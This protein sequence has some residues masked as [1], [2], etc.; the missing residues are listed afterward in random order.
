MASTTTRRIVV[1]ISGS[2]S[3]LQALIDVLNTPAL[4]NAQITLVLSNR[5]AAYGL[6]RASQAVPPIPTAYLA[7]QPFLKAN[8]GKTREDYDAEVAKIVVKENPDI[9]VLAGWMHI[10][11]EEFLQFLD[12]RKAVDVGAGQVKY[13]VPVINLHPAL[14]G[15]FDGAHAIER[16]YEA[17]QKGEI[18]HTG[19]MVHKVVKDVDRGEPV[20]VREVPIEKGESIESFE[21]RLHKI[22]HEIIVEATARV[23][24]E[25][26]PVTSANRLRNK[27][28][29]LHIKLNVF[30]FAWNPSEAIRKL[31]QRSCVMNLL[32][33]D[34]IYRTPRALLFPLLVP[35]RNLFLSFSL[36][37]IPTGCPTPLATLSISRL[38]MA[39]SV[40]QSFCDFS[41][42]TDGYSTSVNS[43]LRDIPPAEP[44]KPIPQRL[45]VDWSDSP[46]L[47]L[48]LRFSGIFNE[49][50]LV[51][52]DITR[53]THESQP[54]TLDMSYNI[55]S[56]PNLRDISAEFG[57][58]NDSDISE[59]LVMS[60]K[61]PS[62]LSTIPEAVEPS[63]VLAYTTSL[64][65]FELLTVLHS[66]YSETRITI[67]QR[68]KTGKIYKIRSKRIYDHY[69]WIEKD[70]LETV[71][72]L[73]A[74]FLPHLRSVFREHNDVHLVLDYALSSTLGEVVVKYGTL[75][76]HRVLFYAAEIITGIS[77]LHDVGIMH[78]NLNPEDI[79]IDQAG[80]VVITNFEFADFVASSGTNGCAFDR[81]SLSMMRFQSY[82]APE[83]L[84]G[85]THDTAVDCWGFGMLLYYMYFGKHPF[86][87]GQQSVDP[88][89]LR[90]RIIQGSLSPESLR[91]IHPQ[92]RDIISKCVER[93]PGV[94]LTLEGIK[95]HIYFTTTS[96]GKV[97]EK[98]VEVPPLPGFYDYAPGSNDLLRKSI[99][100]GLRQSV[101]VKPLEIKKEAKQPAAESN[102]LQV[103]SPLTLPTRQSSQ[104]LSIPSDHGIPGVSQPQMV[105]VDRPQHPAERGAEQLVSRDSKQLQSQSNRSSLQPQSPLSR[106][107]LQAQSPISRASLQPQSP[108][109]STV[110]HLSIMESMEGN[111]SIRS[112]KPRSTFRPFLESQANARSKDEQLTPGAEIWD[113]LDQEERG[114]IASGAEFG[115][116]GLSSLF[117][118]RSKR[119]RKQSSGGIGGG[120]GGDADLLTG[121]GTLGY[122]KPFF[123]NLSTVSISQKLRRK[124]KSP[125]VV[126]E[127]AESGP[128][129]A[130]TSS[131]ET[132]SGGVGR[133]AELPVG[134]EQRGSGIGFQY[135][136]APAE[137]R[138]RTSVC[139][140]TPRACHNMFKS[141]LSVALGLRSGKS[142]AT[143]SSYDNTAI[144]LS[145]MAPTCP[146][147]G[148]FGGGAE[149]TDTGLRHQ[150]DQAQVNCNNE[151]PPLS[152]YTRTANDGDND[153]TLRSQASRSPIVPSSGFAQ[154]RNHLPR[155]LQVDSQ[156]DTLSA[157][158]SP[159][160][161]DGPY[162]P[163]TIACDEGAQSQEHDGVGLV[164]HRGTQDHVERV[165]EVHVRARVSS[166]GLEDS[167]EDENGS[168]D[169]SLVSAPKTMAPGGTLRL[170]TPSRLRVDE[171]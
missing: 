100:S 115:R 130:S 106:S 138:S 46:P 17:F 101:M 80:H 6:T 22:E 150:S 72:D 99:S 158:S 38:G 7:M 170:V 108:T 97:A 57:L 31:A 39:S 140:S 65:D 149:V 52:A 116:G 42:S 26:K 82:Q 79:T 94:R 56:F 114:L 3:N 8:P 120:G 169:M 132:G 27:I 14:P 2:G 166:D 142:R 163:T 16:A 109:V 112:P 164:K 62:T 162:T 28:T 60:P 50:D 134:V 76:S 63:P 15:A 122:P 111:L 48:S 96:W 64:T 107:S 91:L 144:P 113:L 77:N 141:R 78:R 59:V 145:V 102:T 81:N 118:F 167:E 126:S 12:G 171:Y 153:R 25:I 155:L 143:A 123:L 104:R 159:R 92:T 168:L 151:S 71:R 156:S 29:V 67:C 98:Q 30:L 13:N 125:L 18:A 90:H 161:D 41:D 117:W 89:V 105:R 40:S 165:S 37:T 5:K 66:P 133:V 154:P 84:L 157:P 23:L 51:E 121:S 11:S 4:P 127:S 137:V 74:P 128:S 34:R 20:V 1:L 110:G 75:S 32:A 124:S 44:A 69:P 21:E 93:N 86:E 139:T 85:W 47:S 19:A 58:G 160:S 131:T 61:L 147:E 55:Q 73:G 54:T 103:P 119:G 9:V 45:N 43:I 129:L 148:T 36:P 88:N 146:L 49:S 95:S 35:L 33:L 136:L 68:K 70:I 53:Q 87:V 152:P 83:I 10:L 24:D 135:A